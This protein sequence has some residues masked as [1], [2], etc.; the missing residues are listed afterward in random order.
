M[1]SY[2]NYSTNTL[3]FENMVLDKTFLKLR[4]LTLS[5]SIPS[6]LLNRLPFRALELSIVGRNLLTWTPAT[7]NFVD[8]EATNFGNDLN[9]DLGEFAAG[10]TSRFLGGNIKITF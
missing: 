3:M 1:Y 8:P 10:P 7:N 4:E 5:F 2:Y 6:K 9:S